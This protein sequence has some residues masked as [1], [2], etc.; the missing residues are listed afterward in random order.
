MGQPQ[1][2]QQKFQL[3]PPRIFLLRKDF[4]VCGNLRSGELAK[5]ITEDFFCPPN[6]VAGTTLLLSEQVSDKP[7]I[8]CQCDADIS[9]TDK[10]PSAKGG[11]KLASDN[12]LATFELSQAAIEASVM[13]TP[14]SR[15]LKKIII[16]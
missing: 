3:T 13:S 1:S 10:G 6:S 2:K 8:N 12:F 15:F 9:I 4:A 11:V 16:S 5:R 14:T 7:E